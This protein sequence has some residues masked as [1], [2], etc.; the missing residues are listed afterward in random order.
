MKKLRILLSLAL[1][2]GLGTSAAFAGKPKAKDDGF[3]RTEGIHFYKGKNTKPYY[4]MGTNLW[5]GPI[6]GSK[7]KDGNRRRLCA[8]LDSLQKLG[9]NNLR[10]LAGADAGSKNANTVTPYLQPEPGKLDK[11][12]LEGLDF[13]LNEMHKRGMVAVIYLTNSWDWSGGFGFYLKNVGLG[14]SPDAHGE[15]YNQYVEYAKNFY[16]SA[17]AMQLYYNFVEKIVTRKNSITGRRYADDPTI[18]SWQLCNEPRPFG[19]EEVPAF[20]EWVKHTSALIKKHDKNH[21]VSTGSEG[22]IG[23]NVN[24]ELCELVHGLDNVDYMTVHIWPA[25]WGWA[26]RTRLYDDLPNVYVKAKSYLEQHDRISRMINKPYVVEEF[27]YPRDNNSY[28]A[29]SRCGARD[30]F[31]QFIFT[32]LLDSKAEGGP[33]AGC[34]FWGWGG[35][36]R[37]ADEVWKGGNDYLCDPPHEPQGWYSVFD[38]D[39]STLN[40]IRSS[41]AQLN[42]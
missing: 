16:H 24:E 42:R 23:C 28:E 18:M 20:V 31:Y 9:V 29:G 34:N 1:A 8:E 3:V 39:Y 38:N 27:G 21:L 13:M 14:D 17:Q 4:F 33:M 37:P 15:G 36:G 35:S 26:N 19:K 7:G 2:F 41:A 10:I 11:Q 5:Y 30:S 12:L 32:N 25:N 22:V 40:L 6:L